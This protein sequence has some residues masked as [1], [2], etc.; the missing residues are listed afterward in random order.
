MEKF[1][2]IDTLG[3]VKGA[4]KATTPKEAKDIYT[5]DFAY[6]LR[7]YICNIVFAVTEQQFNTIR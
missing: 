7:K 6:D 5:Q 3:G 2:I 4:V 1:K